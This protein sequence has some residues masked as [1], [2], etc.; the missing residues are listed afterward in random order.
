M[1]EYIYLK[2]EEDFKK[3]W[4]TECWFSNKKDQLGEGYFV[5]SGHNPDGEYPWLSMNGASWRHCFV[6]NP[7]YKLHR[8]EI[9][10]WHRF[11]FDY[12]EPVLVDRYKIDCILDFQYAEPV[13]EELNEMLNKEFPKENT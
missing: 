13:S 8:H 9:G 7:G 6:T 1:D 4:N 12:R 5:L 10:W 2:T 11:Y 3:Y